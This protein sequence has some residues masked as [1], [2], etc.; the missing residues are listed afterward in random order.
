MNTMSTMVWMII[1]KPVLAGLIVIAF[2]AVAVVIFGNDIDT[3]EEDQP[4][5]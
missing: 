4:W 5:M 3:E 2:L 1:G